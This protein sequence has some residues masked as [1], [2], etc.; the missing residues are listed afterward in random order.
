MLRMGTS[1][2]TMLELRLGQSYE[3]LVGLK[4]AED[5]PEPVF[6][7]VEDENFHSFKLMFKEFE[8]FHKMQNA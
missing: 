6:R 7:D 8:H 4:S 5:A 3:L 2:K 1:A